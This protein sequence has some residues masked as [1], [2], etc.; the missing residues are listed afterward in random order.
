MLRD[1]ILEG[2]EKAITQLG[3]KIEKNTLEHPKAEE[4]GDFATNVAL[5]LSKQIGENPRTIAEKMI[6]QLESDQELN[7]IVEKMEIAGPGFV[8]FW[9]KRETL[10]SNLEDITRS[11][12]YGTVD[13][14][15]RRPVVVEYSSPNIAKPFTVGH[16]RSTIIGDAVA[17]LLEFCGWKVYRDN[18]L[19]DWGTQFGK[20]IC[21]IKLWGDEEKIAKS[22]SP[23]KDLVALYVKFHEEAEKNPELEEEGRMWFKKLEEGDEEARRLWTKCI[24]W[25]MKEFKRIYDELDVQ[26]TENEGMGY[27][28]SYFENKME[29]V[30]AELEEKGLLKE[31]EGARLVFF[32][33]DELPP[34]MI[35][36]KDGATLY[37]TRDLATDTFRLEKYGKDVTIINE[38]GVEQS[39][40]WQQIYKLEE[41][42]G[43]MKPGQRTHLKHGHYR[44]KEGKMSTRKGN[45]IWLDEVLE[46]A[47]DK[48]KALMKDSPR[49]NPSEKEQGD[50]DI[51]AVAIGAL[52]WNDLKRNS[53]LDVVFDWEEILRMDGNSG[54]YVQY[55]YVRAKSVLTKAT[56]SDQKKLEGNVELNLEERAVLRWIYRFPEAVEIAAV[57]YSPH[58][59]CNFLFELAQ[60][61]NAFYN[62]HYILNEADEDKK[63]LRLEMTRATAEVLKRGLYLLGIEAP[64][65]M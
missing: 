57:E 49:E 60:R 5:Q 29:P 65:R 7:K 45:V 2:V 19:G 30:I 38:V 4:H 15:E 40:Y 53:E 33:N 56:D 41:M 42:L 36:K 59:V 28:E 11:E 58:H 54:P 3:W 20:Q 37:A 13:L 17:N 27:G 9:L 32:P 61:F 14:G 23:V 44:F 43:W 35:L 26:F 63:K 8:N 16:L 24:D 34:L 6:Q 39:L 48:A 31:S 47:K 52:K 46:T 18:H 51:R 22:D 25:S 1:S 64:E 50:N 10:I 12:N 62:A 55:T 21:A